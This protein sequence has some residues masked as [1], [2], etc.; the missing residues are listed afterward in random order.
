MRI[1][2]SHKMAVG[3]LETS[4]LCVL[5]PPGTQSSVKKEQLSYHRL[6]ENLVIWGCAATL[7]EKV[8]RNLSG[9]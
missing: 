9:S 8:A 5:P 2:D 6:L 7:L 4:K 3:S 1:A